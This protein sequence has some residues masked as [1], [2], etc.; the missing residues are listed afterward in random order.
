MQEILLMIIPKDLIIYY[1]CFYIIRKNTSN[2]KYNK[3]QK[4]NIQAKLK[5]LGYNLPLEFCIFK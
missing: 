2:I 4:T 5:N 1:N 3:K